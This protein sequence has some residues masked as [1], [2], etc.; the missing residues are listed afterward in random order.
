MF[1]RDRE[2]A[3]KAAR[4][5]RQRKRAFYASLLVPGLGQV[6]QGRPLTGTA[7]FL[8]F[9]FPFYYLFLIGEVLSYGGLSLLGAQLLLYAL[10]AYDAL[11]GSKR[12]T[13]PCE[14][15]CPAEVLIP[16]FMSF[17]EEGDLEGAYGA[18]LGRA[19][20]PF[21]LGEVCPARC[22]E[23]CGILPGRPLKIREVH[24]EFGRLVLEKEEVEEREPFFEEVEKRVAVI[25][26]GVA[27]LTV[28]YYLA[29]AGVQVELFEKEK[30]LGGTLRF[31]PPFKMDKRLFKK[32][33]EL[34]T[35]FRNLKITRGV[36]VKSRPKGFD[37]VITAV[38]ALKEKRLETEDPR[39]IYPLRFLKSPPDLKGKSLA[40]V[41]AGDTAFDVARLALRRGA[42][43][44]S[45]F[46]RGEAP[47]IKASPAEVESAVR[48]GVK[49]YTDCS[50][51]QVK[52]DRVLFSCRE[53]PFDYLVP[54]IGFEVD[55]ELIEALKADLITGDALTGMTTAVE[56]VARARKT[57]E[58][59]LKLLGLSDRAWFT[60]DAYRPKPEKAGG[61]NLFVVS[62]SSLCQHCGIRVKS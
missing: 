59:A 31:V 1:D 27:G 45:V 47:S 21:T 55:E 20:F 25:G 62:E 37:L 5:L 36:E 13:S 11:K 22:E 39:V 19:P 15:A 6:L 40:V 41:G 18:F 52:R 58:R 34:V 30:E 42:K 7:F 57:A 44:V 29:S 3:V 10:Q 49:V 50:L 2:F 56:A 43:E 32:E 33:I 23:K 12:E 14:D 38:G 46:Y 8:V 48:E 60:V 4:V 17:C 51:L 54:A 61:G 9:L 26:G 16:T 35:S 53:A 24:R 28:A